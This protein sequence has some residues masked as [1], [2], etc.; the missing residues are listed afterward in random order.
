MRGLVDA[1]EGA[2]RALL[3]SILWWNSDG[4]L[5]EILEVDSGGRPALVPFMRVQDLMRIRRGQKVALFSR[6]LRYDHA[7]PVPQ[8]S[9]SS[10][11]L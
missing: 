8:I 4:N 3:C 9:I 10:P 1:L 2:C 5:I 6:P 7:S 11:Q